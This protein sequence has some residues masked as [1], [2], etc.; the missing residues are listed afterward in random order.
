VIKKKGNVLNCLRSLSSEQ[1]LSGGVFDK[2]LKIDRSSNSYFPRLYPL[3]PWG[4]TIDGKTNGLLDVPL[5]LIK[6]GQWAQVPLIIGTNQNEGDIFIPGLPWLVPGTYF[7]LDKNTSL[8]S[9]EHFFN[10]SIANEVLTLYNTYPTYEDLVSAVL[11]DFFFACP[12][13]RILRAVYSNNQPG[14]LYHWIFQPNWI[15]TRILGD[16]HSSE[17]E[18]VFHNP[19]PPLIHEF[20]KRDKNMSD[21]M[22]IYWTNF[23]KTLSPNAKNS[24]NPNW[25]NWDPNG[26]MNVRLDVPVIVEQDLL[27]QVC[28]FWDTVEEKPF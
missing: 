22:G 28:A 16:Y 2:S 26:M 3:M 11:R 9:L 5:N 7:P 12:S 10:S 4:P 25:P 19:W 24:L 18:F 13:R 17:L 8:L 1:I 15:D 14:W 20:N 21:T 23:A 6:K 27:A